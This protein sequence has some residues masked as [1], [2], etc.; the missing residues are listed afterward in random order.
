MTIGKALG[1]L[2]ASLL[3]CTAAR[4]E[5][6]CLECKATALAEA[7]QCRAQSAP[8]AALLATCD[9][10]YA[11]MGQACQESAC[12]AD[13]AAAAAQ[14]AECAKHAEAETKKCTALPPEVRA[15]CE[16]RA[17][18]GK[19]ACEDKACPAPKPK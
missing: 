18:T 8:D 12:R 16:A 10:R 4:G 7:S 17:A 14:C 9:K 13:A 3:A 11:E 15:A 5:L 6:T 19:K 2:L 1:V